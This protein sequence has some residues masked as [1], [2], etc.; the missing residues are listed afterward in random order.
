MYPL[1]KM[2]FCKVRSVNRRKDTILPKKG[3]ENS[4][5]GTSYDILSRYEKHETIAVKKSQSCCV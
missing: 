3:I 5:V 1:R 4:V 2:S